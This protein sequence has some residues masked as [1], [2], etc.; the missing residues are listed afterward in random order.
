MYAVTTQVISSIVTPSV[1]DMS[2][3]A[4]FTMLESSP[5]MIVPV[6]TVPAAN[7]RW[8]VIGSCAVVIGR[9]LARSIPKRGARPDR[10]VWYQEG[11]PDC[12]ASQLGDISSE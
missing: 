9:D 12:R 4:T 8:V 10:S 7:Q 3:S 6:S 1:P 5:A 2:G 11:A